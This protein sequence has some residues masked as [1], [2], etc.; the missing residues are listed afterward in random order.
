MSRR[1]IL[2]RHGDVGP[3][4][5]RRFL[6]A[7]DAP[8][9]DQGARECAGLEPVFRKL[10]PAR[11][12]CS[13]LTRARQTAAA[14]GI[15]EPSIQP[16]LREIAFGEWEGLTFE[17]AQARDPERAQRWAT[18]DRE[19]CFPGG[20]SVAQFSG[21]VRDVGRQLAAEP[22]ERVVAFTHAGVIRS[23]ICHFLGLPQEHQFL[24][25]VRYASLTTF[26]LLDGRGV[27]TGL[28]LKPAGSE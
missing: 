22:A 18:G 2:V 21:R 16:G 9:S 6:G 20:E 1:V 13:P 15:G 12:L 3:L 17:E 5:R 23:L 25:E 19:L 11:V 26:D 4:H 7:T 28:N 8:L 10:A 14:V 24:F 27:L